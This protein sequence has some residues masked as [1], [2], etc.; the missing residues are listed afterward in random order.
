MRHA[1]SAWRDSCPGCVIYTDSAMVS[2]LVEPAALTTGEQMDRTEFLRR[3]DALPERKL[4]ELIEGVVFVASPVARDHSDADFT[5]E[6]LLKQYANATPGGEGGH[7]APWEMLKSMPQPDLHLRI[8][9]ESGGQ[10][11]RWAALFRRRAGACRRNL[12]ELNRG[13]FWS[14]APA[15]PARR[16]PGIHHH[17]AS[18][19]ANRL[20]HSAG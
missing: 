15:L 11:F 3:W 10:S 8:R 7:N 13:R 18:S 4:A 2:P 14:K 5:I 16:R 6:W 17:R 9:P 1:F 12:P 19:H 20:A